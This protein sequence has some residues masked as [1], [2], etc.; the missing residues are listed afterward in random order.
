MSSPG[1]LWLPGSW[2]D[3]EN[4]ERIPPAAIWLHE[5]FREDILAQDG[6]SVDGCPLRSQVD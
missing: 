6:K 5:G 3:P 1:S 2:N 4:K